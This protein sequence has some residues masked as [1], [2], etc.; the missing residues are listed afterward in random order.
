MEELLNKLQ[1]A[2]KQMD[3]HE[4]FKV[5]VEKLKTANADQIRRIKAKG[6]KICDARGSHETCSIDKEGRTV[7]PNDPAAL[8]VK[9]CRTCFMGWEKRLPR[10]EAPE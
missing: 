8:I 9:V 3:K 1:E 5:A 7:H 6:K 2:L 10:D 4:Q